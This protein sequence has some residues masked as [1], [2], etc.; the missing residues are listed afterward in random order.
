VQQFQE[1]IT[2]WVQ[3]IHTNLNINIDFPKIHSLFEM[4]NSI[5]TKGALPYTS[6]EHYEESHK[7]F[8]KEPLQDASPKY[9]ANAI[10]QSYQIQQLKRKECI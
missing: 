3:L 7:Y 6:T 8:I 4:P 10:T 9:Q 2:K 1:V 5:T